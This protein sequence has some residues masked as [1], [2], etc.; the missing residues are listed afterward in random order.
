MSD[1]KKATECIPVV[2][3]VWNLRSI[4]KCLEQLTSKSVDKYTIQS[5]TKVSYSLQ[6]TEH[7]CSTGIV[8]LIGRSLFHFE[9]VGVNQLTNN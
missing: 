6:E 5:K 3:V 7:V 4:L 8:K 9:I 1:N 2:Q